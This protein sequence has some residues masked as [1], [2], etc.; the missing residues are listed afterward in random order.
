MD[1]IY[2]LSYLHLI[3]FYFLNSQQRFS[4]P[5]RIFVG[6][7][8]AMFI[9]SL[10]G[11]IGTDSANYQSFYNQLDKIDIISIDRD[12]Y[13]F[14]PGFILLTKGFSLIYSDSLFVQ[15]ILS[16]LCTLL[17]FIGF[18]RIEPKGFFFVF[19]FFPNFYFDMTMNGIRYGIAFSI[20]ICIV[21]F[22]NDSTK[23][24]V[25]LILVP[26]LHITG[27]FLIILN[28]LEKLDVRKIVIISLITLLPYWFLSSHS[29][30]K[31]SAYS[32]AYSPTEFSGI[33]PLSITIFASTIL[34]LFCKTIPAFNY[35][36]FRILAIQFTF[37]GLSFL[38]YA[39]LRLEWLLLSFFS[40][41]LA[42]SFSSGKIELSSTGRNCFVLIGFLGLA[43]QYRYYIMSYGYPPSPFLPYRFF[44]QV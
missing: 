27:I 38:S 24:R 17:L 36:I 12:T 34:I 19:L 42:R 35:N 33:A 9:S 26:F 8:P 5:L 6:I 11:S 18:T 20:F 13:N 41:F 16:F 29:E 1:L 14:E 23:G 44:W 7:L 21:S 3:L 10:R 2:L 40:Y 39:G 15:S 31:I 28:Y 43:F 4:S 32:E 25:A 22:L 37:F 30:D